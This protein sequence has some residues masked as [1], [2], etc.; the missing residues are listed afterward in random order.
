MIGPGT[1][2]G[3]QL[4][5]AQWFTSC[6]KPRLSARLKVAATNWDP[7]GLFG[8]AAPASGIIERRLMQQRISTD[9]EFAASFEKM[10]AKLK[11][12]LDAKR[13]AREVP[14]DDHDLVNHL[15]DTEAM[16]MDYEVARCRPRL[17][18]EFFALLDRKIGIERFSTAPDEEK[19][20]ELEAL[21][22]FL[23]EAVAAVDKTVS[24]VT[25]PQERMV[26]LLQAKDKKATLLEMAGAGEIDQGL[27]DLLQQNIDSARQAGQSAAADF[28]EKVLVAA[29]RYSV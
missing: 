29:K 2:A 10:Q 27:F 22:D 8:R 13:E 12:E 23:K 7:E 9:K 15:L 4:L 16:E 25:A 6:K 21:R 19:L 28:M 1:S 26:K 24:S 14:A 18:A 5:Q 17:T 3:R 11:E 20:A